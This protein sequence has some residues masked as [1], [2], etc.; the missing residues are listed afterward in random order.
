MLLPVRVINTIVWNHAVTET[1]EQVHLL[2][3]SFSLFFGISLPLADVDFIAVHHHRQENVG[4]NEQ[5]HYGDRYEVYRR[6]EW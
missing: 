5:E 2:T 4:K 6:H 3:I 1:F